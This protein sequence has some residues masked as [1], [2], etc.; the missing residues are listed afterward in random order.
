MKQKI[1]LSLILVCITA[2]FVLI[3]LGIDSFFLTKAVRWTEIII[4]LSFFAGLFKFL[5]KEIYSVKRYFR[6]FKDS[7]ISQN[8][9]VIKELRT[10]V[11]S[12]AESAKKA[13][14][15][16]NDSGHIKAK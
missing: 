6:E 16:G 15:P 13:K 12:S 4:V 2:A 11:L 3:S 1:V 5:G 8:T 7:F 14:L 10:N 9:S